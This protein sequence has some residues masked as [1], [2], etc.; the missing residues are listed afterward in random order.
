MLLA[1]IILMLFWSLLGASYLTVFGDR[2]TDRLNGVE[3]FLGLGLMLHV[4]NI[5]QLINAPLLLLFILI[6]ISMI[7]FSQTHLKTK[8]LPKGHIQLFIV[9]FLVYCFYVFFLKPDIP[10]VSW[11]SWLGWELKAKQWLSH[12]F[13]VELVSNVEWLSDDLVIYNATAAYPDGL[14]LL[15]Y[16]GYLIGDSNNQIV[17]YLS[18][19]FYFW[20]VFLVIL[21]F[22]KQ[23]ANWMVL[24]F[25]FLLLFSFPLLHN[26]LNLQGYADIWLAMYILLCVC[27]LSDWNQKHSKVSAARL[28][29][30]LSLLPLF[31]H[32]GWVWL[33][34][35]VSAQIISNKAI[36]VVL[37]E[38]INIHQ[39]SI[40][41]VMTI[42]PIVASADILA[43]EALK[44]MQDNKINGLI[45][46]DTQNIPVGA[47]NMHDLLNSG[48]L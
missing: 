45:I 24:L 48:V 47:M 41:T 36:L 4:M 29:L 37:D 38:Q 32:E 39:D 17:G 5:L 3:P 7:G 2:A 1:A 31:K 18:G 16:F 44:I 28:V 6:P 14:P 26:H 9:I 27:A 10:L 21:R 8:L 33:V 15:Y 42:N 19:L 12:G 23:D 22:Q 40:S 30:L 34:L 46:V 25:A 13:S 11:D 20:L 35:L 43:A